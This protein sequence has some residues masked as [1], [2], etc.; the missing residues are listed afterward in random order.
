MASNSVPT[1]AVSIAGTLTQN[2]T[3]TASNTLADADGPA[4]L[5]VSYQWQSSSDGSSW[6]NAATGA[7]LT[8]TEPLVGKFMRVLARYTDN[9]NNT[10][11]V[12]S[13]AS[14]SEVANVNDAP[15]G[16]IKVDG[17]FA[18]NQTISATNTLADADGLGTITYQWQS[19]SDGTNW[20]N[21]GTG[22]TMALSAIHVGKQIRVAASYTDGRGTAESVSSTG[23][24]VTNV[25]D[26]PTG[27]VS[28]AGL[29]E[30]GKLLTASHTLA[31]PDGLGIVIYQWQSSADG[32]KWNNISTGN[33]LGLS[34]AQMGL[35]IRVS[36]SYTDGY[37]SKESVNSDPTS[38]VGHANNLPTGTVTISGTYTQ[39]QTLTA[40]N[41]LADV[42]GLGTITYQWQSSAD[43]ST[44]AN[45]STGNTLTLADAQVGKYIRVLANYTDALGANES[46]ASSTAAGGFN[47]PVGSQEGSVPQQYGSGND[48]ISA[49]AGNNAIDAG[50]GNN[51]V[52]T[53][54]GNDQITTGT[55]NDKIDAGAGD[56][57]IIAGAGN[58]KISAGAGNDTVHGG[59]GKDKVLLGTGMD[60]FVFD[61]LAPGGADILEQFNADEDKFAFDADLFGSFAD[62][63]SSDNLVVGAKAKASNYDD[64]L[65]F[66][67]KKG[68]LYFDADGVGRDKPI[69]LV[70]IKLTLSGISEDSFVLL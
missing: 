39:N 26:A 38:K 62:G 36:A 33:T 19:S 70:T 37:G 31:D 34:E 54:A 56:D 23:K 53:G 59:A 4:S 43:N 5:T 55:G 28:I 57:K 67:T 35:F 22:P 66:D 27:K 44:W 13:D 65:L 6:S 14:A 40:S 58:D 68:K 45:V 12:A 8:L 24:A 9:Q 41:D 29:V 51:I 64:Y 46:V 52:T 20:N 69:L 60:V 49:L 25:N 32:I 30:P 47:G 21:L 42:D 18:E 2:E 11:E 15:T 10:E 50:D 1:G 16:A 63:F 7:T 3:L 48:R 61:T 17:N